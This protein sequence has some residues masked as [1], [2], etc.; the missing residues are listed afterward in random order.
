VIQNLHCEVFEF[1]VGFNMF[2]IDQYLIVFY[3]EYVMILL[4]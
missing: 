2:R 1:T 3:V 4:E